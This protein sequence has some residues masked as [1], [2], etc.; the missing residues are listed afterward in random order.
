ME[1]RHSQ[2]VTIE[3]FALTMFD[4]H[5]VFFTLSNT[6]LDCSQYQRDFEF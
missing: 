5:T 2:V 6:T 4:T 3:N 1:I